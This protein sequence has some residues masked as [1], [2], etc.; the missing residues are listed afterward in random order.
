MGEIGIGVEG[1]EQ[2]VESRPR[3][4]QLKVKKKR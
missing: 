4:G 3:R 1:E 2:K